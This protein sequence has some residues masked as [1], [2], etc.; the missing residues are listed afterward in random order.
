MPDGTLDSAKQQET[1]QLT[2][3]ERRILGALVEKAKTTPD[4]YPLS[5]NAVVTACNQKSNRD[6]IM[7]VTENQVEDALVFLRHK[8]AIMEVQGSGRVPRYRHLAKEFLG[9]E[10][11]EVAVIAELL[12]RGAQTVGELRGRA[13]RMA[14]EQLTDLHALTPVLGRLMEK[15]LVL[16]L[17]PA[18]RGQIV[19]HNL[20]VDMELDR[21]RREASS[22]TVPD[23]E[24]GGT[25][26]REF[27]HGTPSRFAA[28]RPVAA[29]AEGRDV[30]ALREELTA[31]KARFDRLEAAF[32]E[33]RKLLS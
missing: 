3:L 5:L 25:E 17:T 7:Q 4:A 31:L 27:S 21:V 32:D 9:V 6:P 2:A 15:Q 12:L 16:E 18:G 24:M 29:L 30:D 1:R 14:P 23:P 20:Y 10:G 28:P 33:F 22:R 13:A 26:S 19:T 11:A 8:G